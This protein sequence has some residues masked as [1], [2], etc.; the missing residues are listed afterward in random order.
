MASYAMK[1]K[2]NLTGGKMKMSVGALTSPAGR[3]LASPEVASGRSKSRKIG[4]R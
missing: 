4:G 1:P 2:P 3:A